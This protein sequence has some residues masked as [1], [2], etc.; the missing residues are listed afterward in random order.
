MERMT[1]SDEGVSIAE[2]FML[3]EATIVVVEAK[4]GELSP[5]QGA[6]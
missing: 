4:L 6:K 2:E 5:S 3:S 1:G